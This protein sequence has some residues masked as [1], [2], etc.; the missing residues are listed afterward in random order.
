[1]EGTEDGR[2]AAG[3]GAFERPQLEHAPRRPVGDGVSRFLGELE[4]LAGIGEQH[5]AARREVQAL[6]AAQEELRPT[7]A[8]SCW[9][10]LVTLDCTRWSLRAARTMPPSSATA[11]K[12]ARSERSI[13]GAASHHRSIS[14]EE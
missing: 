4:E 11:L 10:R 8:S 2:Q 12:I 13:R 6:L 5:F 1:V 14:N 7:E 9:I 3:G